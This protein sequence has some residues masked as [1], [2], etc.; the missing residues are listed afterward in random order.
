LVFQPTICRADNVLVVRKL[1][2]F[3]EFSQFMKQMEVTWSQGNAPANISAQA[4]AVIQ[5]AGFELLRHPPYLP[6][7]FV[8]HRK[9][10]A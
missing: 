1:V 6:F 2:S 3:Y 4:L 9:W 8:L 5:N 7:V 10:L